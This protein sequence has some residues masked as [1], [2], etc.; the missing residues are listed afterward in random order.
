[1]LRSR[2]LKKVLEQAL[3][4]EISVCAVF[5]SDG[6]VLAHAASPRLD[7]AVDTSRIG[8]DTSSP[9]KPSLLALHSRDPPASERVAS[10]SSDLHSY[11]AIRSTDT[12]DE[13]TMSSFDE[14]HSDGLS[15]AGPREKLDDDLAIA[16]NL[17]QS[18]EHLPN[19]IERKDR[20]ADDMGDGGS[21]VQ[22]DVLSNSLQMVII[23]CAYGKAAVTRLGTY[24]LF[25][26]SRASTP[27]GMLKLKS[28]TLSRFLEE[29]LHI[30]N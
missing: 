6:V 19:L 28:D 24:R 1:M 12:D 22:E 21:D 11:G 30:N 14:I 23:E 27:L 18:Y 25:L 20:D 8:L 16:A 15:G 7:T 29:C 9:S 10:N 13:S 26:L 17:W 2:N 4:Q 5:N 3:T